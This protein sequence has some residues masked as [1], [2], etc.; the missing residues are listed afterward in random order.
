MSESDA[1]PSVSLPIGVVIPAQ[2]AGGLLARQLDALVAQVGP[3]PFR[4]VVVLDVDDPGA[5]LVDTYRDRLDLTVVSVPMR[6]A[7]S[8]RNAGVAALDAA[9]LLFCDSDDVVGPGWVRAMAAE[10][11][12]SGLCGS[13]MSVEWEVCPRWARPFYVPND[14]ASVDRFHGVEPYVLSASF[15]IDRSLFDAVG[16][17]DESF[18]GAGGEEVDLCL[19]LRDVRGE[20]AVMG[21]VADDSATVLYRPRTTFRTIARQR[22]GYAR[23]TAL[24]VTRH[25]LDHVGTLASLDRMQVARMALSPRRLVI[26]VRSFVVMR[27]EIRDQRRSTGRPGG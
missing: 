27:R 9:T 25:G 17:F 2:R 15:G 16:G 7:A 3:P 12:R 6:G 19:R 24:V 10:V 5:E 13:R 11:R 26:L 1:L 18:P 20:D 23:G 4:V 21:L 8:A 22:I 14:A